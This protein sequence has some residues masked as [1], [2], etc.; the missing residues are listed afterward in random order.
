MS[1]DPNNQVSSRILFR[2]NGNRAPE[3]YYWNVRVAFEI[4]NVFASA[5]DALFRR[6]TTSM[7]YS[8]SWFLADKRKLSTPAGMVNIEFESKYTNVQ[9]DQVSLTALGAFV[10]ITSFVG[11]VWDAQF[12]VKERII[13]IRRFLKTRRDALVKS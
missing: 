3:A 1:S 11:V 6:Y 13:Q 8:F 7:T 10:A 2:G 9:T 12:K 5:R 4:S